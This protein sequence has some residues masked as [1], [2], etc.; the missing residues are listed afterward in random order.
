[1]YTPYEMRII[2]ALI[3]MGEKKRAL[4]LVDRFLA[5]RRPAG[6]N[7]WA[8]VVVRDP[9]K[10]QFLGDMP[11]AWIASDFIRSILDAFAYDRDDGTL[12]VG[13]GVP[14]SWIGR[15]TLHVGPLPTWHGPIDIRMTAPAGDRIVVELSGTASPK[16]IVVH[17]PD[18]RPLRRSVV[19]GTEVPHPNDTVTITQLPAAITFEY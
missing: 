18:E 16:A 3:R 8:E 12:V 9:R 17:S 2:G 13:A 10:P 6:W 5:D 14:R 15:G 19:D 1:L 11:H 4:S 7:E